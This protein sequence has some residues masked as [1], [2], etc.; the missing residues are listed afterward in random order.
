MNDLTRALLADIRH[1]ARERAEKILEERMTAL[2]AGVEQAVAESLLEARQDVADKLNQSVRRLR[3]AETREEWSNILVEATRGFCDRAVLFTL[4]GTSLHVQSS[5]NVQ[6]AATD[7][8][9]GD[10]APAFRGAIESGDTVVAMRTSGEMSGR[11]ASWLGTADDG[12]FYL[13]PIATREQVMALLYADGENREVQSSALE[14]LTSVA[15]AVL[16]SRLASKAGSGLVNIAD[17]NH[18]PAVSDWFALG[19]GEQDLHAR[20]QRFA[21]HQAAEIRLYK[22]EEVKNGRAA[23]DLYTSLKIDIDSAREAFRRDFLSAAPTMVDYLHLELVRT[24]ANNEVEL[25]GPNYPG[26]LV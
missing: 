15:G 25:L 20:A 10:S 19:A 21:R 2:T 24:L 12:K 16:E 7:D 14:L 18:K 6:T 4:E 23:R 13:F 26:P 17:M 5:R 8:L 11:L 9:A 3:L 22:S 1:T